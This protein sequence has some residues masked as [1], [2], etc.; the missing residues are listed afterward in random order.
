MRIREQ[1]LTPIGLV[2]SLAIALVLIGCQG[3][4]TVTGPSTHSSPAANL[5][6]T[7]IGTFQPYESTRCSGSSAT[8]TLQ[9]NGSEITG[10]LTTSECGV[11]GSFKGTIDGANVLGKISMVGCT[12]GGVS[13]TINGSQLSMTIGDLTKPLVTGDTVLMAGGVVTLSR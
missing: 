12:G 13:G 2:T 10:L 11:A 9:Q 7:W 3:S 8:A 6:G 5:S 4:S 1:N